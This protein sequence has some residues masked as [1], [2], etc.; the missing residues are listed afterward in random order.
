MGG[1]PG[2]VRGGA[3][4]SG[5]A[6]T[7]GG[8]AGDRRARAADRRWDAARRLA[9]AV[10]ELH[11]HQGAHRPGL[12]GKPD[13]PRRAL[14][15]LPPRW[16]RRVIITPIAWVIIVVLVAVMPVALLIGLIATPLGSGRL[17]APRV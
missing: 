14:V 1:C 10:S 16:V 4:A 2:G 8:A 13:V 7:G 9:T 11:A 15:M 12:R 6:R 3:A 5:G 17:R